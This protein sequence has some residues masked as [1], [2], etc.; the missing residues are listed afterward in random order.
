MTKNAVFSDDR[1]RRYRLT[2]SWEMPLG[3][4]SRGNLSWAMLNPSKAGEFHDDPTVRKCV[5]FAKRWGFSEVTIINLIPLVCTDPHSLPPWQGLFMDN[6]PY[7]QHALA[8]CDLFVVAWGA[9]NR[10]VARTVAWSEHVHHFK[11]L[12][13]GV[14]LYCIGR[15][16][17]GSPLHPSRTAYV[18]SPE[19]WSFDEGS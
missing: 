3:Q 12:A 18:D 10:D 11:D 1:S 7:V 15:T 17:N 8:E 6:E 16:K 14:K 2:R 4:E 13:E 5:G 9:V 19:R